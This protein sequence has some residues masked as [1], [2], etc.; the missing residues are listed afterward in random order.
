MAY[1]RLIKN[2]RLS[3]TELVNDIGIDESKIKLTINTVRELILT[4]YPYWELYY[5]SIKK[6]IFQYIEQ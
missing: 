4:N 5:N 2:K 3:K 1:D 6:Y